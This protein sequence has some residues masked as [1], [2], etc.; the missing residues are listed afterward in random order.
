MAVAAAKD[1]P[2]LSLADA[3]ELTVLVARK[4]PRRHPRFAARWLLRYLEEDP[5]TTIDE[6][7]LASSCLAALPGFAQADAMDECGFPHRSAPSA[8]PGLKTPSSRLAGKKVSSS[9]VQ[10]SLAP[11]R[12]TAERC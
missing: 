1:L 8:F 11:H 2:Q 12:Y 7:V 9:A 6:V 3:L 10:A 5:E 4:D